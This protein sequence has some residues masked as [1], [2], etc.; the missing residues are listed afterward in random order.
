MPAGGEVPV[1]E[2]YTWE[3]NANSGKPLL[4][5]KE[6]QVDFTCHYID[7]SVRQQ[8]SE[9]YKK[10]N[11]QGTIPTVVHDGFVMTESTPPTNISMKCSTGLRCVRPI[12]IGDGGCVR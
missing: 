9:E 11:P 10:I 8:H 3:P 12:H 5:L 6:K 2:V 7:M 1:L 4:C